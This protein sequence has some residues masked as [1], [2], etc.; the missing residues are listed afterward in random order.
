MKRKM[1][2]TIKEIIRLEEKRQKE[3]IILIPSESF[4][5]PEV[6]KALGS[7]FNNLY[8]EGYPSSLMDQ[9]IEET[10][11][12]FAH[13]LAYYRRYSDRRYYK[14]VE[15]ADLLESVVKKRIAQCFANEKVP[16]EQIFANIQPLSGAA[17]N[18]AV[19]SAL[20]KRGG[21]IMGMDLLHG[22]HLTHGSMVNRSGKNYRVATY[23]V[24]K[25]TGRLDYEIIRRIALKERPN[26]I[27][28]GYSSY[29]WAPDWEKFRSIADEI[30]AYLLADIAHPA[31]LVIAG[32][33]PSPVG[34][35]HVI[36]FT[37]HKTLLG[38]RG[39]V[40]L[41]TEEEKA[42]LIEKAV[43]PGEQ[44]G[45]HVNKFAAMGIAFKIAQSEEFRTLQKKIIEN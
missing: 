4:A 30:G 7:V 21:K 2:R 9:E 1:D 17:A 22:G 38:P 45:P 10:S 39:A 44:G 40:I 28:A 11:S 8:A 37:T 31:G 27:V 18:N 19:Y 35:A 43:F 26:L 24:D 32:V 20:L 13:Q 3:K 14:G 23:G 29:P 5:P 12:G 34:Y 42:R 16:S 41:T 15:Y 6:R 36:T 33:H 25:E